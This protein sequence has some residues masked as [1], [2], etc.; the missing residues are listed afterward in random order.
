MPPDAP[1]EAATEAPTE[2]DHRLPRTVVPNHYRIDIEPDLDAATF[3]GTVDI[4]VEV[5]DR[6]DRVV[7][8]A[9]DLAIGSA[10]IEANGRTLPATVE[11][12]DERER[13][14]LRLAAP[15]EPGPAR[16]SVDFTGILNDQLRGFYRSTYTDDD[17]HERVLATT[18]FESTDARR[19]FP[20]W[21]EPDLKATFSVSLTAPN[22]MTA[23][24]NAPEGSR[25]TLEDG[26]TRIEFDDTPVMSTYLV[27]FIVGDLVATDPVDVDGVPLRIVTPPGQLHLT[28]FALEAGAHAL[29]YFSSYY[30]VPYPG[31][32]LDMVAVPDFG[33]G[34][35]ENLGCIV[36]RETALLID[37]K[38]AT[39]LE[40]SRVASVIAHEIAHMWFG[41]LVTMKWWNGIWLNEA[42]ATFAETKCTAAFRPDWDFWLVFATDRARS[43][44]TDALAATRPIEFPVVSP[45]EADAMFD[46][47]TY[48]K[49]SSV[50]R[51]LELYLGEEAFRKGISTYLRRHAF[52][53]TE[54]ADLWAALEEASGEP[55]GE[56]MDTWILQGGYPAVE[57]ESSDGSITLS[58]RQFRLLG[59][60]DAT[61][62]VPILYRSDA[63][64]GRILLD[65]ESTTVEVGDDVVV[66]AGGEGFYRVAYDDELFTSIVERLPDLDPIERFSVVSDTSAEMLAGRIAAADY[67]DL[68]ERLGDESEI[69]VWMAA[70]SGIDEIDRVISSDDRE[71]LRSF[72]RNLV[73]P[74]AD[75]L[76]W[77]PDD[78]ES[79]RTRALRG[80]LLRSLGN[81]GEDREVIE[82]ARRIDE[83]PGESDVEVVDAASAI[84]AGHGDL[85]DFERFLE[86]SRNADTPQRKVKY[87]RLAAQVPHRDVPRR[88]FD[89][90]LSG[91]VRSQD[92]FWL[93][94]VLLGHRENGPRTWELVTE[95]WD[96]L[97]GVLAPNHRYRILDM[98]KY[99]S[100]PDVA[101]SIREWFATHEIP[102]CDKVVAQRMEMLEVRVG[103]RE[104]EGERLGARLA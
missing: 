11:V 64:T 89:Q 71:A 70:L 62:K 72:V 69:D 99:R 91:E 5:V 77:H 37:P 60:G 47:L 25:T 16:V 15:L 14:A 90:V 102:G 103:L 45:E 19:A 30:D 9:V 51:M 61:W 79:D 100:E 86:R 67:L 3:H 18:Q 53:N 35:M 34:A 49:G 39:Q 28:D 40:L 63:G 24:S 75:Q 54:N 94:A 7:L 95:H 57:V 43:Q 84:V 80:L 17:G 59:D 96:D 6:T 74:K 13:I 33:F 36:Y 26:R 98:I 21:D 12:D 104:R 27:A 76:G 92:S 8:N 82:T 101:A 29:R 66:N 10:S 48:E 41:D 65:D 68:V 58:Q 38:T 2:A 93:L 1:T 4:D 73:A 88:L 78:D 32:K 81:L 44:E 46:V 52:S 56:I 83:E 97:M 31:D 23:V 55:V 42:F 50:L 20:C 22:G 87:L 85:D